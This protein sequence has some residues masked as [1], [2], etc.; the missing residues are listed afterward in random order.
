MTATGLEKTQATLGTIDSGEPKKSRE[1][2]SDDM[3]TSL[4][5]I[6]ELGMSG[7]RSGKVKKISLL[8]DNGAGG[9]TKP[10]PE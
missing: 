3:L 8:F 7:L 5:L 2:M 9:H 1:Y 6:A 10:I 4:H